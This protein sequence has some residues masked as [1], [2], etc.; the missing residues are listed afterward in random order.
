MRICYVYFVVRPKGIAN[1]ESAEQV[2]EAVI[3]GTVGPDVFAQQGRE[4]AS[5]PGDPGL[6][7]IEAHLRQQESA[8]S[9]PLWI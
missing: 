4:R 3:M 7:V 9:L 6:D 8:S 2:S 1:A 5:V